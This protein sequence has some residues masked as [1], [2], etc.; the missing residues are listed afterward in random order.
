MIEKGTVIKA[1]VYNILQEE[2]FK[3]ILDQI[4]ES[5]CQDIAKDITDGIIYK[6][7]SDEEIREE[8]R[9]YFKDYFDEDIEEIELLSH[10]VSGEDYNEFGQYNEYVDNFR[11]VF[12][13]LKL[14]ADKKEELFNAVASISNYSVYNLMLLRS[15]TNAIYDIVD[16]DTSTKIFSKAIYNVENETSSM[17]KSINESN[18]TG[19]TLKEISDENEKKEDKVIPFDFSKVDKRLSGFKN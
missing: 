7:V 10:E 11:M 13:T 8:I 18:I 4:K 2:E 16:K 9:D 5:V 12:D 1:R 17:I 15:V 19:K 6:K 3:D 14:P